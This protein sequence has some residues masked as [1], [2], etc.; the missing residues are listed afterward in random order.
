MMS[1]VA[2]LSPADILF[3]SGLTMTAF[4]NNTG[5]K[6]VS[7][8]SHSPQPTY[9]QLSLAWAALR[10]FEQIMAKLGFKLAFTDPVK[11]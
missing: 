11:E 2:R 5:P 3:G 6:P 8:V 7:S 4:E 1:Q 9:I 10:L